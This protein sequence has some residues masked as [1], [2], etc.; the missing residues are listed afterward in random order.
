MVCAVDISVFFHHMA[1]SRKKNDGVGLIKNQNGPGTREEI[2][3]WLKHE[4]EMSSRTSKFLG[5]GFAKDNTM[6][7]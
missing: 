4:C 3:L 7:N 5:K 6:C 2:V 1:F